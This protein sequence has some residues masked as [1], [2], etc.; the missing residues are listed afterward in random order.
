MYIG[1]LGQRR[2]R[3]VCESDQGLRSLLI[4]L[5]DTTKCMDREQRPGCY[6]RHAPYV[7]N[8]RILCTFES[9]FS[10]LSKYR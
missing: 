5:W 7:M 2:S 3:S 4:E 9:T 1:I 8:Q 10:L 6:F